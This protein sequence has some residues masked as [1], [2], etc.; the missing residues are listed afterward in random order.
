MSGSHQVTQL[1]VAAVKS[2]Q[3][4]ADYVIQ[5]STINQ[6]LPKFPNLGAIIRWMAQNRLKRLQLGRGKNTFNG[7]KWI[8]ICK[9]PF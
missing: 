5:D 3:L 2:L 6:S 7:S 1:F 9:M 8:K 4:L